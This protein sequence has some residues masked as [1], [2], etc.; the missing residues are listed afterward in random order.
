[1]EHFWFKSTTKEKNQS[2]KKMITKLFEIKK[3]IRFI[4]ISLFFSRQFMVFLF[5]IFFFFALR[6]MLRFNEIMNRDFR[7]SKSKTRLS[8]QHFFRRFSFLFHWRSASLISFRFAIL[9]QLRN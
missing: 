1:M 8:V 6:C 7:I 4:L 3:M 2:E 5:L 9:S